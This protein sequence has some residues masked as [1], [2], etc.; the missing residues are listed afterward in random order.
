MQTESANSSIPRSLHPGSDKKFIAGT[1]T[2]AHI[3]TYQ[4]NHLH[5]KLQVQTTYSL[6]EKVLTAFPLSK[7]LC[8][9]RCTCCRA[10]S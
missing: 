5:L 8:S 4:A 2:P 10:T 9:S 1:R 6:S 3:F 7:E